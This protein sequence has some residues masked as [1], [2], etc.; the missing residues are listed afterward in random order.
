MIKIA[1]LG[2]TF[3]VLVAAGPVAPE[4]TETFT[5]R[6]QTAWNRHSDFGADGERLYSQ[7]TLQLLEGGKAHVVDAGERRESHLDNHWGYQEERTTWSNTWSGTWTRKEN[8]LVLQLSSTGRECELAKGGLEGDGAPAI[9]ACPAFDAT[10]RIECQTDE[11]TIG[12]ATATEEVP[13]ITRQAWICRSAGTAADLGG[14]PS[15]WVFGTDACLTVSSGPGTGR[16][17]YGVCEE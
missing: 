5:F 12:L 2:M 8:K 11:M 16:L 6:W 10:P 14:T 13:A 17:T 1:W 9:S 4:G 3:G 15:P 7:V